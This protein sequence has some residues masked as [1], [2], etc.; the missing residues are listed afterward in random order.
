MGVPQTL[1]GLIEPEPSHG[2]R[3]KREYD[4]L[5]GHERP[6]PFGQMY[7]T[8]TRLQRDGHVLVEGPVPGGG[9]DRKCYRITDSGMTYLERWLSRPESPEP[10]LQP[11]LY[12][13]VVIALLSGRPAAAFLD[14]QRAAHL[15][16]MQELTAMRRRGPLSQA[17]LAD[18]GLFHLEADLRWIDVTAARLDQLA[19]EVKR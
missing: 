15:A 5:F 3:L 10:H 18:Y 19:T 2:Y 7:Q 11:V 16:R 4:A 6:L 13:K 1:L 9:P 14:A 12:G 8:L 17:L